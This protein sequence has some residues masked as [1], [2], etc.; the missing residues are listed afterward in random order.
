MYIGGHAEDTPDRLAVVMTGS[1]ETL[2][3]AM[4]FAESNRVAR[5]LHA[6]GLRP[7]DVIAVYAENHLRFLVAA[8]AGLNSGLLVTTVSSAL[9]VPEARHI[10]TDSGA[11]ALITTSARSEVAESLAAS[12]PEVRAC[13]SLDAGFG[14]CDG[15][16]QLAS[17]S[18]DRL[19]F[20]RRGNFMLYSSGTTGRP[21]GV[22]FPLPDTP[23]RDGDVPLV[24]TVTGMYGATS[25]SVYLSTAPL[26]HAAPVRVACAVQCIGAPVL[27]MERFDPLQALR[28]IERYRV[29]TGQWVPTM[30]T[31]M[32]KL[33]R[34]VRNSF[35]VSSLR[36]AVHGAASCPVEVK[37]QM[38]DWWGPILTEYYGS[39]EG[40]GGTMVTA[41]EWLKHPGTV[42]RPSYAA[43]HICDRDGAE[44]PSGETGLIYFDHPNS[45]FQYH[46]D[47]DKTQSI[48]HPQHPTWRTLGDIGH[49]DDDGYLYITDREN[50]LIVSGGVNIYPQEVENVLLSHP[51]VAEAA[52][53]GVND[54]EY[55]QIVKALVQPV[56]WP[57]GTDAY[58]ETLRDWCGESLAK[59]KI[60]RVFELTHELP[61]QDNGKLY[62]NRIAT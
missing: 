10:V 49:I 35:D 5:Y 47:P 56:S 18:G 17:L 31:R 45:T 9:T 41:E 19:E 15:F 40:Y 21:K 51:A 1:G 20:E 33:P 28:T 29:T 52:V 27:I 59:Y 39:S 43:P 42:G 14:S 13:L 53:I 3:Y 60:P 44:V 57:D 58:L 30:F 12:A 55:G 22:R 61:R 4:L 11:K 23:A 32:L 26:H 6:A 16:D 62:K 24:P 36:T 48:S 2:D 50:Y 54:H 8:W 38:I 7:G 46:N 34:D 25:E 37:R